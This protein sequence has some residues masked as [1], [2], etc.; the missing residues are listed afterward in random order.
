MEWLG[1]A[2]GQ[3]TLGKHSLHT[4]ASMKDM[5]RHGAHQPEACF[6]HVEG[7]S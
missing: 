6:R 7:L 2:T 3:K 1:V 4:A 5:I